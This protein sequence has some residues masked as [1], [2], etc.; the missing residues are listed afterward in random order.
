M[1]RTTLSDGFE[2]IDSEK[3]M[4]LFCRGELFA[5]AV[6]LPVTN[7]APQERRW[8]ARSFKSC[9][10]PRVP[11]RN[12]IPTWGLGS[13]PQTF[14]LFDSKGLVEYELLKIPVIID[15]DPPDETVPD[16]GDPVSS[17]S[18][19]VEDEVTSI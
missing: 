14:K 7:E 16:S 9:F 8:L 18:Q 17:P 12:P 19:T 13:D 6:P 10:W 15:N 2:L 11:F 5:Q 4:L 1:S 3:Q